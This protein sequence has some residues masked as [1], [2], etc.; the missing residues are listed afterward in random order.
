MVAQAKE[1]QPQRAPPVPIRVAVP[2]EIVLVN[3]GS[4][5]G[6]T[7]SCRQDDD[8]R[9]FDNSSVRDRLTG[10]DSTPAPDARTDFGKLIAYRGDA[11]AHRRIVRRR[12]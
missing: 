1:A 10:E 4:I 9:C 6:R 7:I 2:M 8:W 11:V 3:D 5:E 12:A